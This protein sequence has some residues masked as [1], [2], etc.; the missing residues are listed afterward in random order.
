[1]RKILF[2][3]LNK[4]T[5]GKDKSLKAGRLFSFTKEKKKKKLL[6]DYF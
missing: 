1:V 2:Q 4:C 3:E 6:F 5:G